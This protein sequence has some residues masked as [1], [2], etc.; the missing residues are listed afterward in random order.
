MS[1]V[2]HLY[3]QRVLS[4]NAVARIAA[5]GIYHSALSQL[6]F[7]FICKILQNQSSVGYFNFFITIRVTVKNIAA[8][9]IIRTATDCSR[10]S[11]SR[12]CGSCNSRL[13]CCD[14]LC[15]SRS[16]TFYGLS[17]SSFSA[18]EVASFGRSV[19]GVEFIERDSVCTQRN[20]M[21]KSDVLACLCSLPERR[22]KKPL[23]IS[24]PL[25]S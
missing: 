22:F 4:R 7:I 24:V 9:S 19:I 25:D 12:F 5:I 23:F 10:S 8:S 1:C 20:L 11:F 14:R 2:K 17:V 18:V 15:C 6:I 16:V 21:I 3:R 13:C